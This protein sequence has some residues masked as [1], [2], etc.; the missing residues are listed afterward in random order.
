M[1][2]HGGSPPA[3]GRVLRVVWP[4]VPVVFALAVFCVASV[5]VLSATRAF[6][7]GESL[8]SKGQKA[9]VVHLLRYAE[10]RQDA[11]FEAF[12]RAIA[13]P[14][15]DRAARLELENTTR[16]NQA[17]ATAAMSPRSTRP[18]RP[19]PRPM[20]RSASSMRSPPRCAST[21]PTPT[22]A[23]PA[24]NRWWRPSRRSMHA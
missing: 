7:A 15:G 5:D 11:D 23:R 22:A 16:F 18:S 20:P 12:R 9:A 4:F 13:V 19:G 14:L 21:W 2:Q 1:Q 8:W 3:S 17:R 24:C 10:T 6:I